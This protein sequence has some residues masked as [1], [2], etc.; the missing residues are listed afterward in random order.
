MY[1]VYEKSP[2]TLIKYKLTKLILGTLL[3]CS[4]CLCLPI[5]TYALVSNFNLTSF[6]T[7]F[8]RLDGGWTSY[9]TN[10]LNSNGA[11]I[12][13]SLTG[14]NYIG[15]YSNSSYAT[16]VSIGY[17]VSL[18][19]GIKVT[20]AKLFLYSMSGGDLYYYPQN[21]Y[22]STAS[23]LGKT[24]TV[25]ESSAGWKQFDVTG[26]FSAYSGGSTTAAQ[27]ST[28][29]QS[30]W[31]DWRVNGIYGYT[32]ASNLTM[33]NGS[34]PPY[35][36]IT[37]E[38]A[39]TTPT[40][41]SPIANSN[42]K[43]NVSLAATSTV[44]SGAINYNWEYSLNGINGWITI[45]SSSTAYNW[46]MPTSI[47]EDAKVYLRCSATANGVTS[48]YSSI[49]SFNNS[50]EPALAAKIAAQSA[51]AKSEEARLA[52]LIATETASDAKAA[53]DRV[54][55]IVSADMLPP[56]LDLD[57]VSGARATSASSITLLLNASDNVSTTFTYS[58]N[59]GE[60]EALSDDGRVSTELLTGMNN[61]VVRVKDQSGNI[62][63]RTIKVWKM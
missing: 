57:T 53:V 34:Y 18:P 21:S 6:N 7:T 56:V 10:I 40:I 46:A 27:T 43:D 35:L 25:S 5:N 13:S 36:Q 31:S 39:P 30:Y 47:A 17:T 33:Y 28:Y 48:G 62:A 63:Q 22:Y 20:S 11:S 52:A 61:I 8:Y 54:Y 4:V 29:M 41:N 37:Y 49:I 3:V 38:Y 12:S 59:G 42:N 45:G 2:F 26:W 51:E 19:S 60:Y 44:A 32:V 15:Y 58:I 1:D 14:S 24:F 9:Q 23:F 55:E 50:L 16:D